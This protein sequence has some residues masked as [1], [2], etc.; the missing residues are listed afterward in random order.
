RATRREKQIAPRGPGPRGGIDG[1]RARQ[2][3]ERGRRGAPARLGVVVA[4]HELERLDEELDVDEPATPVLHVD[5]TARLL[6]ELPLHPRP[7]LGDL[8]E[9]RPRQ[10]I[11]VDEP[12]ERGARAPAEGTVAE[13]QPRAR[14][15]LPLPQITVLQIVLLERGDARAEAPPLAAGPEPQVDRE[16]DTRGRDVAEHAGQ[17]LG[18]QAV[19]P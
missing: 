8:L 18:G 16:G 1:A 10:R 13:D 19:E 6:A 3:G 14:Q 4:V 12:A 17:S 2:A 5:A 11:A 15:R 7:N 9:R